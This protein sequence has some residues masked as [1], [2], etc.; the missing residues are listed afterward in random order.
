MTSPESF[1]NPHRPKSNAPALWVAAGVVV[2]L[3]AI[4]AF[5]ATTGSSDDEKV[6]A[7]QVGE[8]QVDGT[9]VPESERESDTTASEAT[10]D[11]DDSAVAEPA[12]VALP[13]FVGPEDDPAVGM[14]IPTISGTDVEGAPMTIEADGQAKVILFVAHWCPHCQAEVPAIV[15]HLADTPMPD[16]VDLV[17]VS[18]AVDPSAPNYPPVEWLDS[19][20]WD[21]PTLADTADN[22]AAS[23]Y[24]LSG[25]PFFVVVDADGKVVFRTSG[26]LSMDQFDALVEAAQTGESPL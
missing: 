25:F 6:V 16:D 3:L 12:S 14:T 20:G 11:T 13:E 22:L 2:V 7:N 17:T 10:S 19:E 21:A 15:D 26:E 18:T 24:G 4:V 23:Y 9:A 8:V 1:E 5:A